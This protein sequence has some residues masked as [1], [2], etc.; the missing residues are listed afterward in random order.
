MTNTDHTIVIVGGG[1]AG[2]FSAIHNKKNNPNSTVIIIEKSRTVLAKVKISGG[3]R[4]NVTHACFEP[5]ILCKSY[6]RGQ[7]EL[8]G[9]FHQFQPQDTMDWFESHGIPLKVEPDNRVFPISDSS[10]SIIDCLVN[11]A[12]ELGIKIWTAC[13]VSHITKQ[14]NTF[15]LTLGDGRVHQCHKLVLATGGSREG[16][17]F[18]QGLGHTV[19]S[20]IPSL[21]TLK[22]NDTALHQLSGLSVVD[23]D[24]WISGKKKERQRGGLLITHWGMSGPSIIKF[25]AWQAIPLYQA[26]YRI[27]LCVNYLPAY[28]ESE[29]ASQLTRYQSQNL[30]KRVVTTSPF[31]EISHRLWSY[32]VIKSGINSDQICTTLQKNQINLLIQELVHSTYLVNGKSPFKEEFVTCGGVSLKEINFKTMESNCCRDLHI[33]GELLNIDGVTGGFNFQNA[34]TT[35]FLSG[36]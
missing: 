22:I 28:E 36:Q 15:C 29:V 13:S 16:H 24:V 6:P 17:S 7:K 11:T 21:F 34:W 4:C 8:L 2:F 27:K 14:M 1:A 30:K 18:S 12:I 19:V 10:Q 35:G 26:N 9:P 5:K 33:I 32:L 25:S 3:G 31:D 20:P 23:T